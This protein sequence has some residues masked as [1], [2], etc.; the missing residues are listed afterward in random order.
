[1]NRIGAER[2]PADRRTAS[3]A[4]VEAPSKMGD[5]GIVALR[6]TPIR[7]SHAQR[8]F[9]LHKK[10]RPAA[11]MAAS[12]ARANG[13]SSQYAAWMRHLRPR[14]G[15]EIG[16]LLDIFDGSPL[17]AGDEE[18]MAGGHG[19]PRLGKGAGR[20]SGERERKSMEDH[21]EPR[22]MTNR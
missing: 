4:P 1:M 14:G 7:T 15:E 19:G 12:T 20:L 13:R 21:G 5:E 9:F 17:V 8:G 22:E 2:I 10:T 3:E 6:Q 16:E 18:G 11:A